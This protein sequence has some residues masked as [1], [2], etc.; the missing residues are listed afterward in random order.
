VDL[1]HSLSRSRGQD[2]RQSV[3]F[4][5]S[6]N[7]TENWH[8]RYRSGY[9]ISEG[10][11]QDQS[12]SLVRD[13]NRWQATLNLNVFPSEPQDRVLVELAV[14]LRDIPDLRIPYRARRE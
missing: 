2:S 9:D 14:F 7:P 1:T 12:I 11:F 4:G 10:Q 8:L 6:F 5:T 13:L 3:R